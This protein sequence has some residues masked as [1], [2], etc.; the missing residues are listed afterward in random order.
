M[1]FRTYGLT[2]RQISA[3]GKLSR[4]VLN[5]GIAITVSPTQLGQATKMLRGEMLPARRFK[6]LS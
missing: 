4:I 1:S 6:S 3:R 5:A 2:R